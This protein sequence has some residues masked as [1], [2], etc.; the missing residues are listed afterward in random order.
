MIAAKIIATRGCSI[1]GAVDTPTPA[2]LH[3]TDDGQFI[4]VYCNAPRCSE[5]EAAAWKEG[6][7]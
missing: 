4:A 2:V 1:C 3:T 7:S 5:A 6:T